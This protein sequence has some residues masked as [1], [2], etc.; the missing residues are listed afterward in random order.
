MLTIS[1]HHRVTQATGL[2]TGPGSESGAEAQGGI[3]ESWERHTAPSIYRI[4][5]TPVNQR[6]GAAARFPGAG[7]SEVRETKKEPE[8]E[9]NRSGRVDRWGS[10]R[11]LIVASES[12]RTKARGSL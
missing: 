10:L 11:G 12:R 5:T 6:P 7:A 9:G 3:L 8:R 2:G 4:R 1:R